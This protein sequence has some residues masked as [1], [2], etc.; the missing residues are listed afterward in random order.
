MTTSPPSRFTL[1]FDLAPRSK[2]LVAGVGGGFDVVCAL[3]VALALQ[4]DD[5]EVHLASYSFTDLAQVVGAQHPTPALYRIDAACD[6][7]QNGYFPEKHLADWW[8]RTFNR[9]GV[10]WCFDR[11]G[12]VQLR[13]AYAHLKSALSL[14]GVV[15]VDGGVDGLFWGNEHDTGTPSMDAISII[16]AATLDCVGVYA[17]TAFGTEGRG[18]SVRHADA[19]ERMADLTAKNTLLGAACPSPSEPVGRRFLDAVTWI[20]DRMRLE[21]HSNMAASVAAALR[22]CYGYY[23]V[24]VKAAESKIWISPLTSL[25][26]FFDLQA[27]ADAKPYK[28]EVMESATVAEVADAIEEWRN[29]V[30]VR[31]RGDIPI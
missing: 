8:A 31:P 27:V 17:F 24:T 1:P 7:P 5:H 22:G 28:R 6:I 20:H 14:D 4:D 12:V 23:D 29:L 10:V 13:E 18:H 15:L 2:V 21:Q 9:E 19:L 11:V 16:A 25:F 26:W 3:P 30:G